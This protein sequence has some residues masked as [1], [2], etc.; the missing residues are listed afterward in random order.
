MTGRETDVNR[1]IG[2]TRT[3]Y[4]FTSPDPEGR[5]GEERRVG[6]RER[7]ALISS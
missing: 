2:R 5:G 6:L 4:S 7:V 1:G 3:V